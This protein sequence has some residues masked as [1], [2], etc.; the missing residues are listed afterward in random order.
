MSKL[1][2]KKIGGFTLIELLVVIAIIAILAGMLLP[3]LATARE[4]ARRTQ[5]LNNLKQI[6]L[7]MAQYSSDFNDRLPIS[8]ATFGAV[9]V[10]FNHFA[11]L[12]NTLGSA[13]V[14]TCPSSSD[15]ATN[16]FVAQTA[17][18]GTCSYSYQTGLVWQASSDDVIATDKMG[19]PGTSAQYVQGVA[20]LIGSPHKSAGANTLYNDGRV[21]FETK[22]KGTN[23]AVLAPFP[24][25]NP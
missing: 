16:Q 8:S 14:L 11:M 5:C 15:K 3:A 13:K 24:F 19:L 6:G 7:A 18:L 21:A 22:F 10:A 17:D 1:F 4:K 23:T 25:V 20:P 9:T 2:K 12:S